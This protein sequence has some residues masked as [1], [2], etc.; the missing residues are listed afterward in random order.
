[1]LIYILLFHAVTCDLP[2]QL[3]ERPVLVDAGSLEIPHREGQLITYMCILSGFVLTGSNVS[4]CTRNREW[5]P[6]PGEVDCKGDEKNFMPILRDA[7]IIHT[8]IS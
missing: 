1:M 5:E 7:I 8:C 3:L 2:A 4:V 6:D